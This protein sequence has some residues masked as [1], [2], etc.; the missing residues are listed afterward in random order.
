MSR[1]IVPGRCPALQGALSRLRDDRWFHTEAQSQLA[2][3]DAL[4]ARIGDRRRFAHRDALVLLARGWIVEA[5]SAESLS[6][7]WP[8]SALPAEKAS[9]AWGREWT[10]QP[11]N[12]HPVA[13]IAAQLE[14]RHCAAAARALVQIVDEVAPDDD[15]P[16]TMYEIG[17]RAVAVGL[18]VAEAWSE[19]P[20]SA[21]FNASAMHRL[22][23]LCDLRGMLLGVVASEGVQ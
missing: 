16:L 17:E 14:S 3:F 6:A 2:V 12:P 20:S 1:D 9:S 22:T 15:S 8:C 18:H 10:E 5:F 23:M 19:V 4:V 7:H 21:S 13:A 11:Y